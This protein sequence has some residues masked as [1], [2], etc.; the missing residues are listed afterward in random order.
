M[1]V[2]SGTSTK[3]MLD[4]VVY[5]DVDRLQ[6]HPKNPRKHSRKQI[7]KI[8]ASIKEHG[9][10]VPVLVDENS[11]I[12]AGHGRLEAAKLLKLRQV[13]TIMLSHLT[14]AQKMSFLIADNKLVEM[15]AWDIDQLAVNFKELYTLDF[16]PELTAFSTAEIDLI[17]DPDSNK[18]EKK[19]SVEL[20]DGDA[21]AVSR[22]GDV[23]EL[24][25][26]RLLCGDATKDESYAS[27]MG[28][29]KAQMVFTDPPYNVPIDGHVCGKGGIKHKEFQ[30]ASGEM[31]PKEFTE[32][33][34]SVMKQAQIF[35]I[36]G[37]IHYYFMD[38]RHISEIMGAGTTIFGPLKQLSVWNK[39][40]GGMGSFYRSKHE[41]VF[42]FKNGEAPHINNFKL[43]EHG[44]YR[45]NVW[46][47]SGVN[48]IRAGRMQ[49]LEMHPTVKPV[50]LVADAI[51]D[52]SQRNGIILDP[53]CGSGT[54]IMA[55][56]RTGR[57]CYTM[58]L[59]PRYVDTAIRRWQKK[60]GEHAYL[61]NTTKTFEA[62]ASERVATSNKEVKDE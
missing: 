5:A 60:T 45:T 9:F 41:L 32:F 8:A 31:S 35:S 57:R 11:L 10:N 16:N 13:P 36:D 12:L 21:I 50:G 38:W 25:G 28:G 52:C 30:Q 44:R 22:L 56:E 42:I 58:E 33:L 17:I 24:D 19:E 62:V 46:D 49:E 3:A 6:P 40:N 18:K 15:A 23:W 34:T 48:T 43:G 51:R 27:L 37:A 20:P 47:Y 7:Q 54:T 55:A 4:K 61:I 26:H 1:G 14:E 59:D 2:D 39:D 29:Q 53:F